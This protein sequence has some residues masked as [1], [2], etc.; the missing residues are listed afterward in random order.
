MDEAQQRVNVELV[1][2]MQHDSVAHPLPGTSLPGG[3][4][5]YEM[6]PDDAVAAAMAEIH[7]E[8]VGSLGFPNANREQ[9]RDGIVTLSKAELDQAVSWAHDQGKL[10]MTHGGP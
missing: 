1:R 6:P 10:N 9:V 5:S 2:L 7:L 3:T 8:F 4:T